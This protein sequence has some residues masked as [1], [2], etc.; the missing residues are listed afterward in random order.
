M[1]H[2]GGGHQRAATVA[3]A[4]IDVRSGFQETLNDFKM[5]TPITILTVLRD[6]PGKFQYAEICN[7]Q[8]FVFQR[9]LKIQSNI[10]C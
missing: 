7:A 3:I 5:A 8:S 1:S 4:A 10:N 6:V 9:L 2:I